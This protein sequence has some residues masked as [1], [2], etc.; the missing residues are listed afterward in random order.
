M[1]IDAHA[2]LHQYGDDLDSVLQEIERLKILTVAVSMDAASYERTL[3]IAQRCELVL[4][5]FGIHPW[6]APACVGRLTELS[7][8]VAQS[9]MLGE[10]G[11]DHHF[12]KDPSS[13]PAQSEVFEFFLDAASAQDKIVNVHSKGAERDVLELL[14]RSRIRRTIIHWYSGP[15][16]VFRD[17]ASDGA[18]FTIGIQA[19]RSKHM[20]KIARD[21]PADRILLET[22]NPGGYE[23]MAGSPGM[24]SLLG[25]V[26]ETVA[27]LRATTA[28]DLVETVRANFLR[29]IGD[30]PR[31]E[32]TRV[33]LLGR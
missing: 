17:F 6:N 21:V 27:A 19:L 26:A 8:A 20:Q 5:V 22:D 14:R 31:L 15:L 23:W 9:P 32:K 1:L 10:I 24:P 2:H 25:R 16:D 7:A 18:Y 3:E 11:L 4:P 13:Y 28:D 12:I 29:L 30:D 33:R